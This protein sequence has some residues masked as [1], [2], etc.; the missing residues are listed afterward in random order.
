METFQLIDSYAAR[1]ISL[2]SEDEQIKC[3]RKMSRKVKTDKRCQLY[4][5]GGKASFFHLQTCCA[6]TSIQGGV[7]FNKMLKTEKCVLFSECIFGLACLYLYSI[8]RGTARVLPTRVKWLS[9]LYAAHTEDIQ[10]SPKFGYWMVRFLSVKHYQHSN[11]II[12][13]N[14]RTPST[15]PESK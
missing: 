12:L 2:R 6:M 10:P 8:L 11:Q 7:W 4:R 1:G 5:R 3:R 13:T 15:Q 9:I 14:I